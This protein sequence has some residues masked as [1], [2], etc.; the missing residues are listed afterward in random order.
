MGYTLITWNVRG[1][2]SPA[3]RHKVLMMLKRR[4]AHIALLQETHISKGEALKLQK[5]WRGRIYAT[6]YSAF[7][8]GALIWV[9][10]GVPLE[11]GKS[12]IDPEGRHVI[13]E[14]KLNGKD[15]ILGCIYAPNTGQGQYLTDLSGILSLTGVR[16]KILG[17]DF[18]MVADTDMDRST[19]PLLGAP[20]HKVAE[21][22]RVWM[23]NW[24]LEDVWRVHHP[25]E[26]EYSFYSGLHKLHVRL[27]TVICSAELTHC[28]IQSEYLSK[29]VSDHNPLMVMMQSGDTRPA[30]PLWRLQKEALEDS[31]FREDLRGEIR[32]Y[33]G[34]NWNTTETRAT[35]WEALKVVVRGHCIGKSVQI[36][37]MLDKELVEIEDKMRIEE[38]KLGEMDDPEEL[39]GL[40]TQYNKVLEQVRC[41][42][43]KQYI[44][45]AHEMEGRA[46]KLLA[47][48][49]N[50][51]QRGVPL[52]KMQ[53]TGG[54]LVSTQE[55]IN[56]VFRDYYRSESVG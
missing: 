21:G 11:V 48:L 45:K 31:V 28:F 36:R 52:L 30:V 15:L 1:M 39:T 19:P 33:L 54:T 10:A 32:N 27:D 40:K 53:A 42:N 41:H 47:G 16:P 6:E 34:E 4:G 18:N 49:A 3:K 24:G 43:Y 17:G 37:R 12:Y 5:R 22:Y 29:T 23:N 56:D 35:E 14:V 9:R 50:P 7:A 46:S 51:E 44:S 13:L 25:T 38:L 55:E 26:R 8:R 20:I 2:G